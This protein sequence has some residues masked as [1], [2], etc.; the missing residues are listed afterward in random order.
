MIT[1][2]LLDV[3]KQYESVKSKPSFGILNFADTQDRM[4]AC[5]VLPYFTT[6]Y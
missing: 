5:R 1:N 3:L 6:L 4:P 2:S